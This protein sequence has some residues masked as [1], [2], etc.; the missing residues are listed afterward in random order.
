MKTKF[1]KVTWGV[2]DILV[3]RPNWSKKACAEALED[4][5]YN[6]EEAMVDAGSNEIRYALNAFYDENGVRDE[7]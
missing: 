1:A 3:L 7:T 5:E 6:I 4:I 2:E